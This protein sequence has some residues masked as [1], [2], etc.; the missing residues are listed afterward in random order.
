MF[1]VMVVAVAISL[2]LALAII[3]NVSGAIQ[4]LTQ[5]MTRLAGG[6]WS[7]EVP[8]TVRADELGAMANAV[9]VFKTNG[10]EVHGLAAA[11]ETSRVAKEQRATRLDALTQ[12]FEAKAGELVGHV[13]SAATELQATA[14]S[15]NGTAG[16]VTQQAS[17]VAAAAEEASVNVQTVAAAGRKNCRHRS[18][19]DIPV[20]VAQSARVCREGAGGRYKRTDDGRAGLGRRGSEDR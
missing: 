11:Q 12:A 13:S 9:N 15:M 2:L 4:L 7:T 6:D 8:G 14:Q 18:E 1:G 16:E 5:A 17:N 10:I 3:G 20:R 19:G